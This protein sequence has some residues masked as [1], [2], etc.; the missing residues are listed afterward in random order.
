[1]DQSIPGLSTSQIKWRLTVEKYFSS[2]CNVLHTTSLFWRTA[3]PSH[4][5]RL[6]ISHSYGHRWLMQRSSQILYNLCR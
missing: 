3:C 4:S 1:M 6:Y 2:N 5:H